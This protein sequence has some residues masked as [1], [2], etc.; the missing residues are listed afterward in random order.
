[1]SEIDFKVLKDQ[2]GYYVVG[3]IMRGNVESQYQTNTALGILLNLNKEDVK[4][5]LHDKFGS[6]EESKN[7]KMHF[8]DY[9]TASDCVDGLRD[10]IPMAKETGNLYIV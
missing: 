9:Q 2:Y 3:Y 10:L 6:E 8:A 5:F 4:F 1:M 7:D